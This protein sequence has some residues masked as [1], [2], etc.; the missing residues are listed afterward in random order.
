MRRMKVRERGGG[1][2]EVTHLKFV[3]LVNN[4]WFRKSW[5]R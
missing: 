3:V 5:G 2:K 1:V 4:L